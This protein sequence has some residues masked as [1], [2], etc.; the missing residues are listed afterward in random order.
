MRFHSK[1]HTPRG[2]KSRPGK[3]EKQGTVSV[4]GNEKAGVSGA[5][6][7]SSGS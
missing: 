3:E 1:C 7:G 4:G 2:I 6:L 5:L